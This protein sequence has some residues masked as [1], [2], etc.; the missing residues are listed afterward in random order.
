[1]QFKTKYAHKEKGTDFLGVEPMLTLIVC[2][3]TGKYSHS[4]NNGNNSAF[5]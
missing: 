3:K 5:P 2:D 4:I 1:M